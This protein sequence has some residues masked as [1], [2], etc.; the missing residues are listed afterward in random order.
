MSEE[1]E[2]ADPE[3][4]PWIYFIVH[5]VISAIIFYLVVSLVGITQYSEITLNLGFLI[6]IFYVFIISLICSL[7]GR[8]IA[9]KLISLVAKRFFKKKIK[10]WT[11]LLTGIN[12]ISKSFFYA[13]LISSIIFVG[14]V[15]EDI[16]DALLG[17][18]SFAATFGAYIIL[19]FSIYLI[20]KVAS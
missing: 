14:G 6:N 10:K 19:E 8:Y 7:S 4:L 9:H 16:R 17:D 1:L 15:F 11:I 13:T 18:Q 2:L 3:S 20:S 12:G 5:N